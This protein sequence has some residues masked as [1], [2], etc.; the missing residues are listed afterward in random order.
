MISAIIQARMGSTRLPRKVLMQ[1][2]G[3]SL[4]SYQINRIKKSKLIDNIIVATTTEKIDDEIVNH[5]K[6]LKVDY[7]RGSELSHDLRNRVHE[8]RLMR[9]ATLG[10]EPRGQSSS[11]PVSASCR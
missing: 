7:F 1:V 3:E 11:I 2:G 4:L 9:F 6:D 8:P 5:C 10:H